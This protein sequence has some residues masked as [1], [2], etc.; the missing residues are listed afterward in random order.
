MGYPV[1]GKVKDF[2]PN[3]QLTDLTVKR[4][5]A[6]KNRPIVVRVMKGMA[7]AM[8][9]LTKQRARDRFSQQGDEA[10]ARAGAARVGILHRE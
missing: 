2:I 7:F 8:R 1:I 9:W 10:Q 3:Y 4:S 6:E 5:W